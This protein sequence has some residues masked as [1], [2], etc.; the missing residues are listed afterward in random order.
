MS[1]DS[2]INFSRNMHGFVSDR[3]TQAMQMKGKILPAEVVA[4]NDNMI[5]VKFLLRDIP[6]TLPQVTIPLFGPQYVR[7]PMQTGDRGIVI[8]ADTYLGGVSGQGGGVADMTPP[9]N[10]GALVFLPVS[11]T[12]WQSVDPDMLTAYGPE[13]V[14]L[15]DSSAKTTFILRP[16]SIAIVTPDTF[17]VSAGSST[18]TLNVQG[19]S[20]TGSNGTL[21]DSSAATSPAIMQEGFN[22]LV[23]WLNTHKHSNGN[24]GADTGAPT[25]VF[26]GGITH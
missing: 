8:P 11:N 6:W 17:K 22:A 12:E 24:E 14:T 23:Q 7:Y 15:R 1:I 13:G 21:A 5:T 20:L 3:I 9:P 25:D 10:L 26:S 19:W 4:R 18:L 2:K 16:D